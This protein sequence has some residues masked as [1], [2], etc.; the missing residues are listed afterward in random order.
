MFSHT[1]KK[2]VLCLA[3][4]S[5][6][7]P[8]GLLFYPRRAEAQAGSCLA[9]LGSIFGVNKALSTLT[10]VPI[11]NNTVEMSAAGGFAKVCIIEP[12]V[13]Q[14]AKAMLQNITA[15]TIEWINS[16][17]QGNPGFVQDFKGL[18]TDTA[19]QVIG[20]F[21][22]KEASFLCSPFAFQVRVELAETYFPYSRRAACTLSQA[23]QN[24]SGFIDDNNGVGWDRWIEVTTIP[25]NNQYGAFVIAQD[26]LSKKIV[27]AQTVKE[28]YL[29]WGRGFKDWEYCES[30]AEAEAR[31]RAESGFNDPSLDISSHAIPEC[32]KQTPGAIVQNQLEN[33]FGSGVRQL[34]VAN[35]LN[36]IYDALLN[37]LT[38]QIVNGAVG[39]LG[40]RKAPNVRQHPGY[41]DPVRYEQILQATENDDN[42]A[43][44][45]V[46][47][48]SLDQTGGGGA[49]YFAEPTLPSDTDTED[50]ETPVPPTAPAPTIGLSVVRTTPMVSE[51]TSF[52]HE[53]KVTSNYTENDLEVKMVIKRNNSQVIFGN[54]FNPP[55]IAHI[56]PSG[57]SS[58]G[59]IEPAENQ[60]IWKPIFVNPT[61]E[62][63]FKFTAAK[64][65]GAQTGQYVVEM[66]LKN[67]TGEVL[68]TETTNFTIQ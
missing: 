46:I 3:I 21:L 17:F 18:L 63:I 58:T 32:T 24:V 15:S 28:K 20:E 31:Y 48:S 4:V 44:D 25:Q 51:G 64:K 23:A 37:Q 42:A 67:K 16:G 62:Y 52:S 55:L 68:E 10:A 14:L 36:A 7:L 35:N 38:K 56:G 33:V 2:I 43:I 41:G 47:H 8:S 65:P 19:D 66:T 57:V 29:D 59:Y 50:T 30:Q 27:N 54:I 22:E 5:L 12:L 11:K 26:E 39:L 60:I 34:E 61:T 49:P 13:T 45:T 1:S 9:Y 40:G 53:F 6:V